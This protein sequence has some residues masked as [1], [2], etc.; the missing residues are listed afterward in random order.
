M[1]RRKKSDKKNSSDDETESFHGF[2]DSEIET[3]SLKSD[4][5]SIFSISSSGKKLKSEA[6]SDKTGNNPSLLVLGKRQWKPSQKVKENNQSPNSK[7][8]SLGSPNVKK[9]ENS[10]LALKSDKKVS[11]TEDLPTSSKV[12]I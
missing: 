1:S 5:S 10:K 6:N 11:K 2:T 4:R 3:A 12:R 9:T 7:V 8:L